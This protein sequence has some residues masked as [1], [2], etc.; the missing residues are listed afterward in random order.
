MG[1]DLGPVQDA[2]VPSLGMLGLTVLSNAAFST[3]IRLRKSPVSLSG[4][5]ILFRKLRDNAF[6][7]YQVEAIILIENSIYHGWDSSETYL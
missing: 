4:Y 5:F 3:K 7:Y 6:L 2:L 1:L